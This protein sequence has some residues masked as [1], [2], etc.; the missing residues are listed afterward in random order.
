M[1]FGVATVITRLGY[2]LTA[3]RLQTTPTINPPKYIAIGVGATG[4]GRTAAVSDTAL[5]TEVETR[6]S[7]TESV[8]TVTNTGDTYQVVGA[9]TA[10]ASRSVDEAGLFNASTS[11]VMFLSATFDV[12]SL[13]TNDTLQLTCQAQVT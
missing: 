2:N 3:N 12:V 6:V 8:V 7:G 5:S 10:T 13:S 1:S 11:G 9:I 4:A